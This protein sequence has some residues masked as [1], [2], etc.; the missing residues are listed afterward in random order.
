[1]GFGVEGRSAEST[2]RSEGRFRDGL[3]AWAA[4]GKACPTLRLD[5]GSRF[6]LEASS[7]KYIPFRA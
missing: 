7:G 2:S 6:P 1:M 3:S 4:I 5:S